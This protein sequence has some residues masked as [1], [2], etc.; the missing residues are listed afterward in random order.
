[1]GNDRTFLNYKYKGQFPEEI[2][3]R[4]QRAAEAAFRLDEEMSQIKEEIQEAQ[5]YFTKN[6]EVVKKRE[7][8]R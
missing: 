3:M 2:N 7:E 8:K 5:A 4:L 6:K 1:M